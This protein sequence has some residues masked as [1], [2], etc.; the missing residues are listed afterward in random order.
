MKK[1]KKLSFI[2]K[3]FLFFNLIVI[4]LLLLSYTASWIPPDRWWAFSFL[5]IAYPVFFVINV[6]F[7]VI[8][9]I[10]SRKKYFLL[11][12]FA[13]L[14]GWNHIRSYVSFHSKTPEETI[15]PR[16][17]IMSFNVRMF[18]L[19]NWEN[20]KNI[21]TRNS[22]F[23][24]IKK[25][26]PDILCIQEF[27][28]D[29]DKKRNFNTLDTLVKL[30]RAKYAHVD[31][32]KN[33][34]RLEHWGMVTFSAYPIIKMDRFQFCNS[35]N[36]YMIYT[37]ILYMGDTL[38]VFNIH[39][40]SIRL[41]KEDLLF[42]EDVTGNTAEKQDI[43][44]GTKKIYWKLKAAFQ[45]R[46]KQAREAV[47]LIKKS[48]HPVLVCGDFNDTPSSYVYHQM[49][50]QLNDAFVTSGNGLGKTYA[51]NIPSFRIDYILYDNHFN[52]YNFQ[53]IKKKF[54]DHFPV[55]CVLQP[56]MEIK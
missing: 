25:K 10:T 20:Q 14:L 8:W 50:Q 46:A 16:L 15:S 49:T 37:D 5:G 53:I 23:D 38:R 3:I 52:A 24:L 51:G 26:D 22:I 21:Y 13:L 28:S 4:V 29:S 2:G 48:P 55:S 40:E 17:K 45:K 6:V 44:F 33:F 7:V 30:Q 18:D 35:E 47:E 11:S 32:F 43:T 31:Y 9:L 42:V 36:N 56:K 19:Y 34:N 41:G 12:L 39:F 1:K 27:F 54:S